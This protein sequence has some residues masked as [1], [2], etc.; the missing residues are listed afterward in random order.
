MRV[1]IGLF[2]CAHPH[3][4]S[5]A[6][7]FS[8]RSGTPPTGKVVGIADDNEARGRDAAARHDTAYFST[9]DLLAQ[10]LDGAIVCSENSR[11]RDWVEHIARAGVRHILCEKPLAATAEDAQAMINLCAASNV[12]LHMA[13]PCRYA[14]AFTRAL[15]LVRDGRIGDVLAIAGTNRGTM[16][17]GWFTDKELS[18]G[19]AVI[20]HTVHVADLNRLLVGRDAETV[21]AEI[22]SGFYKE[23]WDDTGLLSIT[24]GDG[25]FGTLDTSWSRPKGFPTWGDVTL[26][27][28]GTAGVLDVDLFA[29]HSVQHG[30]GGPQW[31]FWGSNIDALMLAD[32]AGLCA[33]E[34]A[35]LLATG[36]DGLRA[37]EVALAAYQSAHTGQPV[38]VGTGRSAV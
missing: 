9:E 17:G 29:Q 36:T 14:P 33:G 11:H 7:A 38:S 20:D 28:V 30:A 10:G 34:P 31:P 21:Y 22:G 16:P 2:S 24:Y 5:Y 13:F 26:Q 3:A 8:P 25:V 35:P 32:F 27:I 15:A 4:H 12:T 37:L 19:G 23:A 6:E 1:R 18:G